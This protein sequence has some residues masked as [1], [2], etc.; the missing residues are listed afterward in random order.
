MLLVTACTHKR[1]DSLVWAEW[2]VGRESVCG[3]RS[4]S[5]WE[6]EF[7]RPKP[8][9]IHHCTGLGHRCRSSYGVCVREA[10]EGQELRK[11]HF[12][13]FFSGTVSTPSGKEGTR[14]ASKRCN[15][16]GPFTAIYGS[17][18]VQLQRRRLPF[19]CL[20]KQTF[21]SQFNSWVTYGNGTLQ[22][23]GSVWES[24]C[25]DLLLHWWLIEPN[26]EGIYISSFPSILKNNLSNKAR[27]RSFGEDCCEAG[28]NEQSA[29]GGTLPTLGL[30]RYNT[31]SK[32]NILI[33][34]TFSSAK[35]NS[36]IIFFLFK[37]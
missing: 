7:N 19:F 24:G 31:N 34:S 37:Q 14:G 29:P 35:R 10:E 11:F 26:H 5:K 25:Y 18:L 20:L 2:A 22:R 33:R 21:Q 4:V 15:A 13:K 28:D 6:H 30:W 36:I 3:Q 8:V 16:E 27:N 17:T 23:G 32:R 9:A 12:L 1:A